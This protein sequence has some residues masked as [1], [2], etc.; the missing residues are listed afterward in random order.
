MKKKSK[1][2]ITD[3]LRPEYDLDGLL[4][5]GVRGKYADQ[6]REGSNLVLLDEDV[7]KEFS[8]DQAVNEA[9]RLVIQLKK[10]PKSESNTKSERA[11][12]SS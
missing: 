8:T 10:L 5:T 6:V 7:A 11:D 3:E 12:S 2:E 1:D 4:K 9:L